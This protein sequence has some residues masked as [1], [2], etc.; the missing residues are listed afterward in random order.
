MMLG[1]GAGDS[2]F[3]KGLKKYLSVV[4]NIR[5]KR[6]GFARNIILYNRYAV[7]CLSFPCSFLPPSKRVLSLERASIQKIT[8]GPN[9]SLA[10]GI[11]LYLK[12]LDLSFEC[13]SISRMSLASR[14]RVAT[15]SSVLDS[16]AGDLEDSWCSNGARI[17]VNTDFWKDKWFHH[18][19]TFSLVRAF[20]QCHSICGELD[21]RGAKIQ[22]MVSKHIRKLD[23]KGDALRMVH[24]RFRRWYGSETITLQDFRKRVNKIGTTCR[25]WAPCVLLQRHM[26]CKKVPMLR[27]CMHV[28]M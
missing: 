16:L 17:I 1:P 6:L 23:A 7:P 13:T 28:R 22:A 10:S 19:I 2:S 3:D 5:E 14:A 15:K 18:S 8:A 25:V 20:Q 24:K 4:P 12:N 27:C 9:H 21:E 11:M 26:H